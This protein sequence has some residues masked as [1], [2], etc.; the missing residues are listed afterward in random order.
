MA[1]LLS[2]EQRN[3]NLTD[4]SHKTNILTLNMAEV[5]LHMNLE[6]NH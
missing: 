5:S 4:D 2:L 1:I 3:F 6:L